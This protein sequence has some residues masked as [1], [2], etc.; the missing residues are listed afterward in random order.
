MS[1]ADEN[2]AEESGGSA[3][4]VLSFCTVVIATIV[5][6]MMGPVWRLGYLAAEV[7]LISIVQS[8]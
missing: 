1:E 6:A 3:A 2:Q 4:W 8:L 7:A 5:F